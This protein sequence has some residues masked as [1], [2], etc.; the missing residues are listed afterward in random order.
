LDSEA[1][2]ILEGLVSAGSSDIEM[3]EVDVFVAELR[4]DPHVTSVKA[5]H[6]PI[7]TDP[8]GVMHGGLVQDT[9]TFVLQVNLRGAV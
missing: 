2:L 5:Q 4:H 3:R 7:D 8:N 6:V 1:V 9:A